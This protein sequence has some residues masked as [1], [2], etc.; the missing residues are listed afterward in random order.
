MA[1]FEELQVLA[2]HECVDQLI[3]TEIET[4]NRTL[5]P[6]VVNRKLQHRER[7]R[8]GRLGKRPDIG[9]KLDWLRHARDERHAAAPAFSA[10]IGANIRIHGAAVNHSLSGIR[11]AGTVSGVQGH[12]RRGAPG[13]IRRSSNASADDD[14]QTKSLNTHPPV[15][16]PNEPPVKV[17]ILLLSVVMTRALVAM[18]LCVGVAV[19]VDAHGTGAAVTWKREISRIVYEKCASCHRPN[20]R[21]SP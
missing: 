6:W 3:V 1:V 11:S 19:V 12:N 15:V 5:F 13:L 20:E 21:R 18:L 4:P 14:D 8:P 7:T 2:H 10:A 17:E 16:R 9:M